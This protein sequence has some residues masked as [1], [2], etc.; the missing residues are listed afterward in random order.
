[1]SDMDELD[2]LLGAYALDAVDDDER[3]RIEDYLA[4]APRAAAEVRAHREVASVLAFSGADA[5]DGL[6]DRIVDSLEEPAPAPG[7]ELAK[8]MPL[9]AARERRRVPALV[10]WLAATAAA[11]LVAI[12]AVSVFVSDGSPS[13]PLQVA[14]EAARADRNSRSTVLVNAD[15]AVQVEAVVDDRGHGY[16]LANDLPQLSRELTYQLWGVIEDRV[17]SLGV[18]GPNPSLE[19]FTARADLAALAITIEPA[20]GVVSDGNPDGAFVGAFG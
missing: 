18:L 17:I 11:A 6:W 8:V 9:S 1:M 15:S 14:V 7:P 13:D 10:T 12:A 20:G 19:T 2:E 3:R 5:P 16:L 4:V